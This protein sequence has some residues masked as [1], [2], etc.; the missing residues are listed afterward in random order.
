MK[1]CELSRSDQVIILLRKPKTLPELKRASGLSTLGAI[2]RISQL[3]VRGLV[4]AVSPG[5][6]GLTITGRFHRATIDVQ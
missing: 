6:F 1:Q 2:R 5:K 4:D 3:H